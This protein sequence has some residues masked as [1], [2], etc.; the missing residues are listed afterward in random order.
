MPEEFSLNLAKQIRFCF[1]ALNFIS[2]VSLRMY[3]E[4]MLNGLISTGNNHNISQFVGTVQKRIRTVLSWN[5][6]GRL[7]IVVMWKIFKNAYP[8]N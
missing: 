8:E 7:K 6:T 4:N 2:S 3:S 5:T 1:C